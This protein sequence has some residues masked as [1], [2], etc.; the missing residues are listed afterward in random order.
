VVIVG[1]ECRQSLRFLYDIWSYDFET[2]TS[3]VGPA[4]S[5]MVPKAEASVLPI[6]YNIV[7]N[8]VLDPFNQLVEQATTPMASQMASRTGPTRQASTS[9]NIRRNL[10]SQ[11]AGRRAPTTSSSTAD[12]LQLTS[13]DANNDIVVRDE[14]GNFLVDQP[15]SQAVDLEDVDAE[16]STKSPALFVGKWDGLEIHALILRVGALQ[17]S[18][19][20]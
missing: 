1:T 12:T 19:R 5:I 9:S 7:Y 15:Q 20:G 4:M 18:I 16:Q 13:E 10:F 8:I 2:C 14:H 3:Q 17:G 11:A 6:V